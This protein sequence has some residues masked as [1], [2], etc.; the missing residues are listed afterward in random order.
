MKIG[1]AVFP[2]SNC[3]LD[4]LY[5]AE[6]AGAEAQLIWHEEKDLSRFDCVILPGGFSYGDYLRTGSIARFAPLMETLSSFIEKGGLVMGI[7]NGFQILLEAGFLP[8]AMLVNENLKFIC[9]YV[10]LRVENDKTPFTQGFKVSQVI[11]LPIAHYSG[12]YYA[13]SDILKTL[14]ENGQVVLRYCDESGEITEEANPNGS[15]NNIAGIV[16]RD[17]QVFGLM[18][19]PERAVEDILGS[20][21]GLEVFRSLINYFLVRGTK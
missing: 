16:S 19:H 18:P 12:N 20:K 4:T 11:R 1:V 21:D 2:G 10:N 9:Q 6:L 7:C 17:W 8:G 13:P 5:A 15:V 3:D 14:E